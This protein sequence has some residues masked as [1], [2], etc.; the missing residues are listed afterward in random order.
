MFTT[1]HYCHSR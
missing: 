1:A